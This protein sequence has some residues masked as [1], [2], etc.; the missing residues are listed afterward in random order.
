[1]FP[2]VEDVNGLGEIGARDL[3]DTSHLVHWP[4]HSEHDI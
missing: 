3:L 2:G 1:M 4:S